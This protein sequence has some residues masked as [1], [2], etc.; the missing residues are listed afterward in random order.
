MKIKG[1]EI[2]LSF[3]SIGSGLVSGE[4]KGFGIARADGKF[5]WAKAEV[6]GDKVVV[7]AESIKSPV[8][9]RYNW[10]DNPSGNLYNKEGLPAL[11]F[12]TD[13]FE[14]DTYKK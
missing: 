8:A 4:L 10:G 12:R 13:K 1:N 2:W 11:P 7:S 6:R 3:E 5:S 14:P 9:V